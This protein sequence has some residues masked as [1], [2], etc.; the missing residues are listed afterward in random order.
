MVIPP[1]EKL[2][3]DA[4]HRAELILKMHEQ[5][6][7]NIEAMNAKYQQAD[8][9]SYLREEDMFESRTTLLQEGE[10]DEDITAID[11][12]TTAAPSP[13]TPKKGP[14]TRARARELN[15]QVQG[16]SWYDKRSNNRSRWIPPKGFGG[17]TSEGVRRL[18]SPKGS[19][20]WLLQLLQRSVPVGGVRQYTMTGFVPKGT[21][22]VTD[23]S[24][25]VNLGQAGGLM[26]G[27]QGAPSRWL[28][29][30]LGRTSGRGAP[31]EGSKCGA[32]LQVKVLRDK[33]SEMRH[34]ERYS[35]WSDFGVWW[36]K[37]SAEAR[38]SKCALEGDIRRYPTKVS[39]VEAHRRHGPGDLQEFDCLKML[40]EWKENRK[41]KLF[42]LIRASYQELMIGLQMRCF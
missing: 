31:G 17:W 22:E 18:F 37:S 8:L 34:F 11:T 5:T 14:M 28:R 33:S 6:K 16:C 39:E 30:G 35:G 26:P 4:S 27:E 12:T 15:Y 42:Y 40:T 24:R 29:R 2:N 38:R 21:S 3:F 32:W 36:F 25:Q 13:L 7:A 20:V 9:K 23:G 41:K 19:V 1:S 10:D